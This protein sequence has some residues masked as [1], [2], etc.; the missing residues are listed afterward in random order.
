MAD[1]LRKYATAAVVPMKLLL[2]DGSGFAS[3]SDWT[4]GA[5]DVKYSLSTD[6]L[7]F[8]TDTNAT[9][10]PTFSHDWW[11]FSFTTG[12]LTSKITAVTIVNAA[13]SSDA[14]TIETFGNALAMYQGNLTAADQAFPNH[15]ADMAIT[16]TT[17][18]VTADVTSINGVSASGVTAVSA[19]VGT[20]QPINFTG[21]STTA[22][23]KGNAVDIAGTAVLGN[24]SSGNL[25]RG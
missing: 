2:A 11:L 13:L 10:L 22:L 7:A 15:F 9:A 18:I 19:N 23:V 17:G 25:W 5:G 21:T 4:P 3:N 1:E 12:E 8:G 16:A 6:A 24:G 14:F 20:T